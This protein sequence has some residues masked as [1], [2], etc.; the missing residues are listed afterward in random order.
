MTHRLPS[1]LTKSLSQPY[2]FLTLPALQFRLYRRPRSGGRIWWLTVVVLM[3]ALADEFLLYLMFQFTR[4][5][6]RGHF[7]RFRTSMVRFAKPVSEKSAGCEQRKVI[8]INSRNYR[9][10]KN[11]GRQATS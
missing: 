8:G 5:L 2:A 1:E 6:R 9:S 11:P 10:F 4:E 7:A 3:C